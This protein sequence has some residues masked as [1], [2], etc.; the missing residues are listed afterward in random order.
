VGPPRDKREVSED[1][2]YLPS[3]NAGTQTQTGKR[4]EAFNKFR[5]PLKDFRRL[6]EP[7]ASRMENI[8]IS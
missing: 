5:F 4:R 3:S 1:R 8:N 7:Y 2:Q 6:T